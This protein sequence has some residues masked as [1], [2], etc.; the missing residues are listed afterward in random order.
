MW[1]E[2]RNEKHISVQTGRGRDRDAAEETERQRDREARQRQRDRE[3]D[4]H[5]QTQRVRARA[6]TMCS[7]IAQNQGEKSTANIAAAATHH[8]RFGGRPS[9]SCARLQASLSR[10]R[11]DCAA[12]CARARAAMHR[13]LTAK[14]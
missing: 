8:R 5:I 9:T 6:K 7:S 13:K 2:Q 11:D 14:F 10:C 12:V 1:G 3:R 4:A